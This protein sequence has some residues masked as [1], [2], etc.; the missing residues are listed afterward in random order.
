MLIG[1]R[2][3]AL[4]AGWLA[5]MAASSLPP[6][7]VIPRLSMLS[8]RT[9]GRGPAEEREDNEDSCHRSLRLWPPLIMH[10]FTSEERRLP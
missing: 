7:H 9:D 4:A 3:G 5:G 10:L 1:T 8:G 2:L 6:L